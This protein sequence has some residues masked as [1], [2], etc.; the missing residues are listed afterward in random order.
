MSVT[1]ANRTGCCQICS[2]TNS[3]YLICYQLRSITGYLLL[4]TVVNSWMTTVFPQFPALTK[5][6]HKWWGN[7]CVDACRGVTHMF[8]M[9]DSLYIS[10]HIVC[11]LV[12]YFLGLA[13]VCLW[14]LRFSFARKAPN[15]KLDSCLHSHLVQ[16]I[17]L[18]INQQLLLLNSRCL[19]FELFIPA[20]FL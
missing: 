13:S 10:T 9:T 20:G 11:S 3:S 18:P 5:Y 17:L 12:S 8:S 1:I 15:S 4:H 14:A 6:C 7:A 19:L 16:S 2:L